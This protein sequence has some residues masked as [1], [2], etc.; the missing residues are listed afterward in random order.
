MTHSG[1]DSEESYCVQGAGRGQLMDILQASWWLGDWE[2]L[3]F[4]WFQTV[5]GICACGQHLVNFFHLVGIFK[6]VQRLGSEYYSSS[7]RKS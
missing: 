6:I 7:L 3:L 1:G 4:S 2:S 5:S